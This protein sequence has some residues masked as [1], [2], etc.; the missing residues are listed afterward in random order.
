VLSHVVSPGGQD[1]VFFRTG[2]MTEYIFFL[3][4]NSIIIVTIII[5]IHPSSSLPFIIIIIID[6]IGIIIMII[7][8]IRAIKIYSR[9]QLRQLQGRT[10]ENPLNE[11]TALQFI[12]KTHSFHE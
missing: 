11:I 12:G 8:Q 1:G 2:M 6:I 7:D 9:H 4:L 10:A 5:I 3:S